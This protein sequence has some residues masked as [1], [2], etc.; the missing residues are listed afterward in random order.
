VSKKSTKPAG[1]ITR[2]Q[3]V[4]SLRCLKTQEVA[5]AVAQNIREAVE[6]VV[7]EG[8]QKIKATML[9]L[10]D[11][12]MELEQ[13]DVCDGDDRPKREEASP[14]PSNGEVVPEPWSGGENR[15]GPDTCQD[16][17]GR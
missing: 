13:R 14:V 3:Q 5:K 9:D 1:P 7:E 16:D 12:V 11:R 10:I 2:R 4:E 6:Q 8:L 17:A 15:G